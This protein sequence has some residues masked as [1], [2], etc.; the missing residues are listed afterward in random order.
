MKKLIILPWRISLGILIIEFHSESV[1]Q[2]PK[3]SL[4]CTDDGILRE[5]KDCGHKNIHRKRG[6]PMRE[7]GFLS[8]LADELA[9][10][11]LTSG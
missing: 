6:K 4:L 10:T 1:V 2:L 5:I 8:T 11:E 3:S 9:E 7:C